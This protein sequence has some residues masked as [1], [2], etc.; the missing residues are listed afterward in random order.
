[1]KICLSLLHQ[2]IRGIRN[3]LDFI[4][5]NFLDYDILCFTETKL[6][7]IIP[8]DVLQLQG[9]NYFFRKEVSSHSSGFLVYASSHLRPE[10]KLEFEQILPESV[11]IS[12]KDKRRAILIC[13]VYRPLA[14]LSL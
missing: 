3:K 10:R 7:S 2:N 6:N 8:D 4:V 13:T 11:W 9:F 1:M 12:I 5:D 14:I